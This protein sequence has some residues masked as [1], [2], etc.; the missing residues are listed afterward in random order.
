MAAC[1]LVSRD[2]LTG[3][4]TLETLGTSPL[5]RFMSSSTPGAAVGQ[6]NKAVAIA[7]AKRGRQWAC[8]KRRL[9]SA[10]R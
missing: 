9:R 2:V 8:L 3:S 4:C 5:R 7:N 10:D 1:V 6:C